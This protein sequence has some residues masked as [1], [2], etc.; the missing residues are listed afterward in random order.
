MPEYHLI[1]SSAKFFTSSRDFTDW[2]ERR[3][4]LA[5]CHTVHKD[6][7]VRAGPFTGEWKGRFDPG[8]RV[9]F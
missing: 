7:T 9:G 5:W 4:V 6:G 3:E 8:H 2:S 1:K